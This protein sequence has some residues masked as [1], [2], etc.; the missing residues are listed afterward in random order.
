MSGRDLIARAIGGMCVAASW[1]VCLWL[2]AI[3]P[4]PPQGATLLQV[5]LVLASF[6]L[7]LIG[8]LLILNGAKLLRW[9]APSQPV[10]GARTPKPGSLS[11]LSLADDR[12]A[13]VDALTRRAIVSR[14]ER[15]KG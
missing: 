6:V 8:L 2:R 15:R 4:E 1:G 5:G 11:A 12:A 10:H 3:M 14:M 13:R 9:P 7:S